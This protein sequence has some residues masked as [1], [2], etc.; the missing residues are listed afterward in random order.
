[1]AGAGTWI[2][3]GEK[4]SYG[5]PTPKHPFDLRNGGWG[6]W[7][8]AVRTG[9]FRVD[10]GMFAA[11]F[12]SPTSSPHFAREGP[13]AELVSEPDFPISGDYAHTNFLGGALDANRA[14]ERVILAR[15]QLNFI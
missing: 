15:F 4:K 10:E 1:M 13:P 8:I 6:A 3:T 11:G 5:S 12:A 2:L 9:D 14:S 7:E